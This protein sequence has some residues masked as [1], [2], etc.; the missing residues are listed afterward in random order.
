[1]DRAEL[2]KI[3]LSFDYSRHKKM[4]VVTE[5]MTLPIEN[6]IVS[7]QLSLVMAIRHL[8]ASGEHILTYE[9]FRAAK[10]IAAH[11]PRTL[12]DTPF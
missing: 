3:G 12:T 5:D 1:M 8:S 9:G 4:F 6:L 7:E 11:L 2:A 10:K